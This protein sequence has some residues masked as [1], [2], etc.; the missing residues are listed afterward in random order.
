MDQYFTLSNGVR[1]PR[2]G[3]GT[4]KSTDGG[5]ESAIL[6]ALD[7]GYRLLDTAAAYENE[8]ETGRAIRKSGIRRE[9]IFL[10]SKVWRTNL[11][12]GATKK[13][14]EASLERLGTD[15][16]DLFLLHWPKPEPET[17]D[18]KELD[19]E[20]WKALEE[21]YKEGK[22]RAI[23][24]SNFLP[25]HLKNLLAGAEVRPMVNQLE[26]HVGYMQ[27]T[28]VRF[29][30]ENGIQPQAWSPLG[31]RR[32][33]DHEIIRKMAEKYAVTPAQLLLCFLLQQDIAV[34][35]KASSQ[36]R[37]RMNLSLPDL[38]ITEEDMDYLLALPQF[39][40]S[41][42]HPDLPRVPAQS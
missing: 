36:E 7:A 14:F 26:L 39:G 28:A 11:G 5:D 9:D 15:Y 12:Y 29:S 32:I 42:E 25:H 38:V 35:P 19:L 17:K 3:Y 8:E 16:L 13:S 34:I 37:M 24:V 2:I 41:G 40:W 31:R 6:A 21:F 10:T 1:M 20:S 18:W 23:G 30:R 22:V 4:Y 27:Q 33:L